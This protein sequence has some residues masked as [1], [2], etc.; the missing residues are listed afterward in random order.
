M[1]DYQGPAYYKFVTLSADSKQIII[2]H[3]IGATTTIDKT[4]STTVSSGTDYKLGVT[5]RGG[6]VNVSLN[7]AVVVSCLYNETV[8]MGGYGFIS[9]K[10]A[11]SGQTS[12]DIVRLKTDDATYAVPAPLLSAAA[13]A[14]L[15]PTSTSR[16]SVTPQASDETE[17]FTDGVAD[18]FTGPR[19]GTWKVKG[20]RYVGTPARGSTAYS[21]VDLAPP[22]CRRRPWPSCRPS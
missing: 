16:A 1:F 11:T 15:S 14:T 9:M 22:D 2:G 4:Y 18:R 6:L 7:G 10:G 3:R 19:S 5:L 17:D 21:L 8:T 12:F 13:P 20:G